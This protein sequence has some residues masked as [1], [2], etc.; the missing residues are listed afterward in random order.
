MTIHQFSPEEM[1]QKQAI[2]VSDAALE[3]IRKQMKKHTG[4]IG[5]RLGLKKA[6]CS[7]LRYQPEIVTSTTEDD[8]TFQVASDVLILVKKTDF[9]SFLK[10]LHIDFKKQGMNATFSY[11]NPNEKGSCGCGESFTI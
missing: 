7:G 1:I 10:G 4:S 11:N 6:G 5:L 3:H 2:T 8:I 9:F